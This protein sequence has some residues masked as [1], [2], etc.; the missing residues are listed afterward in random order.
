MRASRELQIIRDEDIS[1]AAS[2]LYPIRIE[3]SNSNQNSISNSSGSEE[4]KSSPL[5]RQQT[6][7]F[8]Q[9]SLLSTSQPSR[10][11]VQP[12]STP[13]RDY[14]LRILLV[15]DALPILKM[16]RLML[17][18]SG[19]YVVTASNGKEA[20]DLLYPSNN[21]NDEHNLIAQQSSF[22]VILMDL[23]MPVMDGFEAMSVIRKKENEIRIIGEAEAERAMLASSQIS[24]SSNTTQDQYRDAPQLRHPHQL[25]AA[26]SDSQAGCVPDVV[27]IKN[28]HMSIIAMSA[29]S[30][31]MSM[32][33]AY[34]AGADNFIPKP[35]KMEKFNDAIQTCWEERCVL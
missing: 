18:N 29:N 5:H 33:R 6:Q 30:D 15:D 10:L 32:Q 4:S 17:E 12:L 25:D 13:P 11:P 26:F 23:Q 2:A 35:F 28:H 16:L 22:D 3:N 1:K 34:L 21:P 19:H 27:T 24:I 7:S 31:H 14:H 8:Q 20:V 9:E